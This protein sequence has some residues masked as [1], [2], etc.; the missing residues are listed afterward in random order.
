MTSRICVII[1]AY[2]T[3]EMIGP[4]IGG[5]LKYVEQVLVADDGST[6]QTARIAAKA[7]AEVIFIGE[8]RG[9]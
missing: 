1:P 9:W 3:E 4:V 8:N 7:G 5:A 6:D 2:N